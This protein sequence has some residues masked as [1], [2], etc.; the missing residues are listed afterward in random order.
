[1]IGELS[2]VNSTTTAS[3]PEELFAMNNG[4][5]L[6]VFVANCCFMS[7]NM[8]DC[9]MVANRPGYERTSWILRLNVCVTGYH[10]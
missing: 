5:N 6:H 3:N 4:Q 10:P 8:D 9:I 2:R 7:H 1:M